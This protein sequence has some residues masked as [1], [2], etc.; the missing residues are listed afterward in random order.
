MTLVARLNSVVSNEAQTKHKLDI[1]D[2]GGRCV[3]ECFEDEHSLTLLQQLEGQYV[4][5]HARLSGWR[6]DGTVSLDVKAIRPVEST[7]EVFYHTIEVLVAVLHASGEIEVYLTL[8]IR[9]LL[10]NEAYTSS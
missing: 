1:D 10:H 6:R 7:Y 5:I 3:A 8:T 2:E 9:T 4:R